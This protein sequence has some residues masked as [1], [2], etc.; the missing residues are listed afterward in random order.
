M[1]IAFDV[2]STLIKKGIT[3]REV[4]RHDVLDLYRWF[5]SHGCHMYVWSGGGVEYAQQWAEKLGLFDATIITKDEY[6]GIDISVDDMDVELAKVNIK[7]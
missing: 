2:D 1:R 6:H 4:P 7:V 5:Q 3:G